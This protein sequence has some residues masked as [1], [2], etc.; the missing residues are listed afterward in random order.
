MSLIS[1]NSWNESNL[2]RVIEQFDPVS[3]F[4]IPSTLFDSKD[5]IRYSNVKAVKLNSGN[6]DYYTPFKG[7]ICYSLNAE[8][9]G[10]TWVIS[11]DSSDEWIFGF[12]GFRRDTLQS[13]RS[14]AEEHLK[15]D[16]AADNKQFATSK[17]VGPNAP[18]FNQSTCGKD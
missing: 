4:G 3:F 10:S 6:W 5:I 8:K 7:W 16:C 13:L 17:D 12:H 2:N 9:F 15:I 1:W 18:F 11:L 14:I